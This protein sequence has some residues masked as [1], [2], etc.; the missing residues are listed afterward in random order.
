MV[1]PIELPTILSQLPNVQK[2]QNASQSGPEMAQAALARDVIERQEKENA[3]VP[4]VSQNE[5]DPDR[6]DEEQADEQN[7]HQS[8]TGKKKKKEKSQTEGDRLLD[9]RI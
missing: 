8:G 6:Q 5:L 4:K 3:Q 7:F 2:V 1:S 9:I